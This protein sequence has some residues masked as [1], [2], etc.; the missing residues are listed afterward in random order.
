MLR[1]IIIA[2]IALVL[3]GL[4]V[5]AGRRNRRHAGDMTHD[6]AGHNKGFGYFGP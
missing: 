1:F 3:I 5:L 6:E 2:V 4:L